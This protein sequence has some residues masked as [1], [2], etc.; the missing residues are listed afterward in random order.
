M[1]SRWHS[2]KAHSCLVGIILHSISVSTLHAGGRLSQIWYLEG[3]TCSWTSGLRHVMHHC[4]AGSGGC[5]EEASS[6]PRVQ[7]QEQDWSAAGHKAGQGNQD[8]D[9]CHVGAVQ[10]A[11]WQNHPEGPPAHPHCSGLCCLCACQRSDCNMLLLCFAVMV[12]ACFVGMFCACFAIMLCC[13]AL[14]S[15]IAVVHCRTWLPS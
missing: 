12:C 2:H 3:S 11:T 8:A 7:G 4:C 1:A 13:H 10:L 5:C 14:L 9:T 6:R 15:C